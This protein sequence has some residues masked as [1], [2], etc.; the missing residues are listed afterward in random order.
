M[1]KIDLLSLL[2]VLVAF[3]AI[4]VGH[5]LEGGTA[6]SLWELT[7]LVIVLGGTLGATMLQTPLD[8]FIRAMMLAKWTFLP[9]V[10][11][12]KTFI[13]TIVRWSNMA[14]REGL[15]GLE[16]FVN[17]EKDP[18]AKKALQLL[19][20][21][22]EPQTI[23]SVMEVDLITKEKYD[24]EA[25]RVFEGMGGYSPTIGI[26]G[27]V[28][29]LIHVMSNLED[30]SKLGA[31]I[32]TAF[33]ATIYGV[34]LANLLFLPIANKLNAVITREVQLKELLLD[35]II[36]IAEGENPRNIENRLQGYFKN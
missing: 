10:V 5:Q 2:G 35:G 8:I 28:L 21:G 23:R 33:V 29:G 18:F 26:L 3:A 7:A 16:V 19:V 17:K 1:T 31:G 20:D 32:A 11:E 30:P 6:G 36:A 34:G 25:A 24:H 14:R 13:A 9:P 4:V 12:E 15:L 27:A 22:N